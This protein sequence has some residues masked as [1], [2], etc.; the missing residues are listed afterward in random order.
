MGEMK[1]KMELALNILAKPHMETDQK[2]MDTIL[3]F[4]ERGRWLHVDF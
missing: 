1:W 3:I 4:A 2:M